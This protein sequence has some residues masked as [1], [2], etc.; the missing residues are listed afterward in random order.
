MAAGLAVIASGEGGPTE[1]VTHEVDGLLVPPRDQRAL[2]A[3]MRR[4][5][6]NSVLRRRLG[7]AAQR[8]AQRFTPEAIG[9][10]MADIYDD[11]LARRGGP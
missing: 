3:A 1:V 7:P 8:A 9:A 2:Q 5:A 4:V 6:G 10:E 11:V